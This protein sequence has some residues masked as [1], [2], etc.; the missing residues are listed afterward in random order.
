[1]ANIGHWSLLG[2]GLWSVRIKNSDDFIG[3]SLLAHQCLV[4]QT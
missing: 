3:K 2:Y 1:M 4:N